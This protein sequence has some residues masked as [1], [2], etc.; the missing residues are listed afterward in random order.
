MTIGFKETKN[1]A[2]NPL[3]SWRSPAAEK[4]LISS[5]PMQI[6]LLSSPFF[7][8]LE[9]FYKPTKNNFRNIWL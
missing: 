1:I 5:Y 2:V 6:P 4:N 7:I 9:Q 3:R 8:S